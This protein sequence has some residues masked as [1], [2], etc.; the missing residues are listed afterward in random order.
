MSVQLVHRGVTE[1]YVAYPARYDAG[2][3]R[4][5]YTYIAEG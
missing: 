4:C 5:P 3:Q 1:A 2:E